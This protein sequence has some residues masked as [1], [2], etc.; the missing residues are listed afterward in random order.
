MSS[1]TP[2]PEAKKPLND[3]DAEFCVF[4]GSIFMVFI[5]MMLVA[6]VYANTNIIQNTLDAIRNI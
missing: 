4:F 1:N 2:I 6:L 3:D 5:I